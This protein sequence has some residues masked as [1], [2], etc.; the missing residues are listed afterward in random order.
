MNEDFVTK[1]LC[2]YL[3]HID[4]NLAGSTVRSKRLY[5]EKF[6]TFLSDRG[7]NSFDDFDFSIVYAFINSLS[8]ASQT[9]SLIRFIIREFFNILHES[10]IIDFD[11]RTIFPVIFTNKRDR[12]IS[13]Y[14]TEEIKKLIDALD[15]SADNYIMNKCMIL[16]AAQMG[17]RSSDIL[18]LKF[19]DIKW[20]RNLIEKTQ[21]KTGYSVSVPMPENIKLLLIDYIK[22][23][24]PMNTSDYV[25]INK[26]TNDIYCD[27]EL[28]A[29]V[30]RHFKKTDVAFG[31]RKIGPHA[32][33]HSLASRLLKNNTPMPVITGVLG[34]KNLNTTRAYLNIDIEALRQ[35]SLE[36][37]CDE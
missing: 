11:G 4:S 37:N 18:K 10:N 23:Y 8:Y 16:L 2:F 12:I 17:L 31:N 33:R 13:F 30:T 7:V 15:P 5:I 21:V 22:N 27:T 29:I 25:F 20:D 24:R 32:L 6:L 28:L 9:L 3:D 34:H 1:Y 14:E 36:I 26:Y 19:S 35:M